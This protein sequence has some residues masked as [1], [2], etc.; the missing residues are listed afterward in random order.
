MPVHPHLRGEYGGPSRTLPAWRRFTPTCVGNTTHRPLEGRG[1]RFTPTCVGNTCRVRGP[2]RCG[3]VHPHLRGEYDWSK[4]EKLKFPR[5]TPTC[6]GNTVN[7]EALPDRYAVHPHLRGEY[8]DAVTSLKI[9]VGSPP[10]AWGIRLQVHARRRHRRFT[11]TCVGNTRMVTSSRSPTSGSPP[12]A[13][14]IR[15]TRPS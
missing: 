13:W 5:F 10:P 4:G 11:P 8:Y 7:P 3:S 1:L 6:V 14:G 2:S 9:A 12:P 15:Y